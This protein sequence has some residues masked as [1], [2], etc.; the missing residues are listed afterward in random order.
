MLKNHGTIY[1]A[2]KRERGEVSFLQPWMLRFLYHFGKAS[3]AGVI[4]FVI[5]SVLFTYGPI[6]R[7]EISYAV[8]GP[9]ETQ[10]VHRT[11]MNIAQAEEILDSIVEAESYG[12]NSKFS[13]VIPKI[14]AASN[15]LANIDA[16]DRDEYLEALK[17]GVAHAQGTYF[18]GQGKNIFLF[19]HSTDSP[20]NINRYNAVFYL[21]RKLEKND[22]VYVFFGDK[23]YTYLVKEKIVTNPADVSW[24]N[25]DTN[26]ERLVLQTCDPPGTTWRRLIVVAEPVG[27][28]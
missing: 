11:N 21:L 23:K 26:H 28:N 17:I 15:V 2:G 19:S 18:P 6:L 14:N 20:L 8:E 1:K 10:T 9:S 12:V 3:G 4:G 5:I 27:N 25:D 24:I 22:E 13:I 7:E 16:G